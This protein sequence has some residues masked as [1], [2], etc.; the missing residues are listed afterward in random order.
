VTN[1]AEAGPV[2]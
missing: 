2:S 1:P